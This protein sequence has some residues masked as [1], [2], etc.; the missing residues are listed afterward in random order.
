MVRDRFVHES[1]SGCVDGNEARLGTVQGKMRESAAA[2]GKPLRIRNRRP[3]RGRR[4]I[5]L[6]ACT[7]RARNPHAVTGSTC[8]CHRMRERRP[9]ILV[10]TLDTAAK[11]TGRQHDA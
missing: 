8:K 11:S 3:E 10:E 7:E 1:P 4:V 6:D 9:D 2:A 5:L